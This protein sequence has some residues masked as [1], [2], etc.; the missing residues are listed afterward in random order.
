ME[1]PAYNKGFYDG[2]A[3]EVLHSARAVA[4]ILVE[5]LHPSSVVDIGCGTGLWLE[6]FRECGVQDI[7]GVDNRWIRPEQLQI[8][9]ERFLARDLD[10]PFSLDREFDLVVCLEVAEHLAPSAAGTLIDSL[11][12]LGP[13]ILFSAAVPLQ[14]GV[15]HIN[16]QWPEYWAELFRSHGYRPVDCLRSRLWGRN[17]VAWWYAQNALLYVRAD[18]V[19]S[20]GFTT[21]QQVVME[22][23]GVRRELYLKIAQKYMTLQQVQRNPSLRSLLAA[24]PF[25]LVRFAR[26][27][28]RAAR[29]L[30]RRLTY[31]HPTV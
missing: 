11:V 25:A 27:R 7:L 15:H 12:A 13:V 8:A 16:E 17:D 1:I 3:A 26:N 23:F 9:S 6:A 2:H 10:Q 18:K 14:G 28:V 31:H 30:V 19:Q 24:L 21:E 20:M 4:P 5:M 22:S 29:E